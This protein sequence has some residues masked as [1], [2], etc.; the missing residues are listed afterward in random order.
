MILLMLT[1]IAHRYFAS[2]RIKQWQSEDMMD[3]F[4]TERLTEAE[5]EHEQKFST[6]MTI[7]RVLGDYHLD[8]D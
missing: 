4:F 6:A 7:A 8:V 2:K 1:V 5:E 3:M